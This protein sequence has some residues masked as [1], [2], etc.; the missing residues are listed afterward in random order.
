MQFG[1]RFFWHNS[2]TFWRAMF[3]RVT[4][5]WNIK[6]WGSLYCLEWISNWCSNIT[7]TT[8]ILGYNLVVVWLQLNWN[9]EKL[10]FIGCHQADFFRI[11]RGLQTLP[12][13]ALEM[14]RMR[15]FWILQKWLEWPKMTFRG[16]SA[17]FVKSK[18][19]A[20]A[21]SHVWTPL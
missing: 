15:T 17:I 10:F 20:L 16:I 11:D 8:G 12:I 2:V 9:L 21:L 18:K 13:F 19:R 1:T 7:R 14:A 4:A 3:S 5:S 6:L